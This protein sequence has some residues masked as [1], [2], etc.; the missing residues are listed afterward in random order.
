MELRQGEIGV[1]CRGE[2]LRDFVTGLYR[3]LGVSED[4][5]AILADYYVEAS[6]LG[7][8]S[9]ALWILP[10]HVGDV[11][12][13]KVAARPERHL[14]GGPGGCA[15]LDGG[16]GP[17]IVTAALAMAEAVE[18]ARRHGTGAVAV[19]GGNHFGAGA[20]Y[21]GRA[22]KEG[23]IGVLLS[24]APGRHMAHWRA[25]E[26]LIGNNPLAIGVPAGSRPPLILDMAMSV[27]GRGKI[28]QALQ[29][30]RTEIPADWAM[31]ESGRP[32]TE[33]EAAARA[34]LRPMGDH[35]GAGLAVVIGGI[36]AALAGATFDFDQDIDSDRPRGTGHL[37]LAIDPAAFGPLEA[38]R[39]RIDQWIGTLADCAPAPGVERV[40]LPGQGKLWVREQ[41][42]REG[43]PLSGD[44]RQRLDA[45]ADRFGV[46][47]L[48]VMDEGDSASGSNDVQQGRTR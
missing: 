35:K 30:G 1:R 31:D 10:R 45:L 43:I 28:L 25:A 26:P 15:T 3:R 16:N 41:R 42:L 29:E 18:R 48:V 34:R 5:L 4:D 8:D 24:N 44:L 46:P 22:V 39:A 32:V 23:M 47:R 7:V 11:E 19:R 12:R 36:C 27:A 40:R 14:H 33:P 38:Y 37:L 20:Y 6:L 2:P 13:D 21:V 17:G 9:H